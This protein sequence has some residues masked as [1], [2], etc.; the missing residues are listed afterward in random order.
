MIEGQASDTGGLPTW[1]EDDIIYFPG[2]IPGFEDSKRFIIISVPEY[3]PFH[4]LQCIEGNKVRFA[5]INPLIFCKDYSPQINKAALE[6]LK[7][8][9]PK[10]LLMYVIVTLRSPL[11]QSSANLM[12]P[13]FV[14]YRERLGKQIIIDDNAYSVREKIID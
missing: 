7:I 10:D 13:L 8:T 2:G 14:N 12:G 1:T 4:W 5:V 6:S 11:S 3:Q 9:D